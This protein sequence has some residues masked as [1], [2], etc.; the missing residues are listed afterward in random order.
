M[1][2]KNYRITAVYSIQKRERKF[3][4]EIRAVSKEKALQKFYDI[5][6]AQNI[7][8]SKIRMVDI[9]E[10]SP[11]DIKNRKLQKIALSEKPALYVD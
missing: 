11:N 8:R 2:V 1:E 5:L 9:K 10:I 7:R 6:G 3:S 4:K